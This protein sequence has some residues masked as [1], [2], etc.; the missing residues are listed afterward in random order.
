VLYRS[1]QES[2]DHSSDLNQDTEPPHLS[3]LL[4]SHLL[5]AL[6]LHTLPK[7][8]IDIYL[9]VLQSESPSI[10]SVLASG[11]TVCA[12]AVADAGIAMNGLA[13]GTVTSLSG[14]ATD[15]ATN[16][17]P[18]IQLDPDGVQARAADARVTVG[19]L[20]ALDAL[21]DVWVTGEVT[22]DNLISVSPSRRSSRFQ[23][24]PRLMI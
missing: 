19:C 10:E 22:V 12:A 7:S 16:A 18:I 1:H 13:V 11:L 4:H 2:D 8:S 24:Y 9:L 17:K 21:S 3:H 5:P 23:K 15:S 14:T 6:Q 20:P